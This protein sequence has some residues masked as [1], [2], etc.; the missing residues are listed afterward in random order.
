MTSVLAE[1]GDA[2]VSAQE[3]LPGRMIPAE[4]T[5]RSAFQA[6][7][8]AEIGE[9]GLTVERRQTGAPWVRHHRER[10]CR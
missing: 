8:M 5:V 2:I 1:A 9:I 10:G 6:V 4:A 3:T 7:T